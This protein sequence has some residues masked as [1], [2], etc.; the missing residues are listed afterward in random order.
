MYKLP[1]NIKD[2][3]IMRQL[4]QKDLANKL[5]RSVGT[6]ANWEK[7]L[8]TPPVEVLMDLSVALETTPNELLGWSES[9]ELEKFK[10]DHEAILE[11]IQKLYKQKSDIDYQ[12]KRYTDYMLKYAKAAE[13]REDNE[14]RA[15]F[16]IDPDV[17]IETF[18]DNKTN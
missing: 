2:F 18:K 1:E 13:D 9:E 10:K 4:T 8:T 5:N 3:R 11:L 12:L 15:D 17:V 14:P 16:I 6:I 7:G